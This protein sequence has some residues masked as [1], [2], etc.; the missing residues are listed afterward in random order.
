MSDPLA[1][2]PAAPFV[3]ETAKGIAEFTGKP[4]GLYGWD[5][6]VKAWAER[7][8]ESV[9]GIMPL[10]GAFFRMKGL[11]EPTAADAS[12]FVQRV[13]EHPEERV[14]EEF[15]KKVQ[16]GDRAGTSQRGT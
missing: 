1:E 9:A 7:P 2:M 3:K 12:R 6:F 11:A 10:I 13:I 16:Q 5:E 8:V 14:A 15:A 4:A